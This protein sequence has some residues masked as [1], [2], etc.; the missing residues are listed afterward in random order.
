MQSLGFI[1]VRDGILR[2]ELCRGRTQS[3]F[4]SFR[5][6]QIRSIGPLE[7]SPADARTL[8]AVVFNGEHPV[9][10]K[11]AVTVAILAAAMATVHAVASCREL[12]RVLV[13]AMWAGCGL[14]AVVRLVKLTAV[15]TD[16]YVLRMTDILGEQMVW[17]QINRL[18]ALAARLRFHPQEIF[19]PCVFIAAAH[20]ARAIQRTDFALQAHTQP[21]GFADIFIH[22]E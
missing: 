3:A 5:L 15:P 11:P 2:N 16:E 17:E 19:H 7:K 20:A 18:S 10:R 21:R 12:R 14:L 22:I 1:T 6:R 4:R 8:L 13:M 9:I